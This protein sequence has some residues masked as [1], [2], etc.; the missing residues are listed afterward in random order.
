MTTKQSGS[1]ATT[2]S[3]RRGALQRDLPEREPEARNRVHARG[4]PGHEIPAYGRFRSG[5]ACRV[6]PLVVDLMYLCR[7]SGLDLREAVKNPTGNAAARGSAR[8]WA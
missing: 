1:R 6:Y 5:G 8:G 2:A 7:T 3:L 4:A